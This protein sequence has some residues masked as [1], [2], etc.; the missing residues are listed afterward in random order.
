MKHR[1]FPLSAP[2]LALAVLLSACGETAFNAR[3]IAFLPEQT[4]QSPAPA[5]RT[6][7]VGDAARSFVY[8]YD[9]T[10]LSGE[11][12]EVYR[13][14]DGVEAR[15]CKQN[16]SCSVTSPLAVPIA[17]SAG[18]P[19]TEEDFLV[20]VRN[21]TDLLAPEADLSSYSY[22]CTT[23]YFVESDTEGYGE[24]R[25]ADRFYRPGDG[26]KAD[27]Y[28]FAYTAR[29]SGVP[30]ENG[31]TVETD[32]KGN[33]LAFR[34]D[35]NPA[36]EDFSFADREISDT[37][38]AYLAKHEQSAEHDVQ[39]WEVTDRHFAIVDGETAL[40]VTVLLTCE[41]DGESFP[42]AV[43]LYLTPKEAT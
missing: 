5:D 18:N 1:F 7:P 28:L 30:S 11:V 32:G 2:V 26:E 23:T 36:Y 31:I 3:E 10:T 16:R 25:S 40:S 6:L 20:L 4:V 13:S 17:P 38:S 19:T 15:F 8:Q 39:D 29:I 37:V 27:S 21:W 14:E 33:L 41:E 12:W 22:T 34:Y 9:E 24:S 43:L 35:G 42:D